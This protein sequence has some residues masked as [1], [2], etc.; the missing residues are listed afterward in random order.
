MTDAEFDECVVLAKMGQPYYTTMARLDY[1]CYFKTWFADG[2]WLVIQLEDRYIDK[3]R[4]ISFGALVNA[5]HSETLITEAEYT[6]RLAWLLESK[7]E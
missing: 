5:C 2:E 1:C 4:P 3:G 7:N 6:E